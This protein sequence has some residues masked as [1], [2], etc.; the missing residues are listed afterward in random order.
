MEY[1]TVWDGFFTLNR[2]LLVGPSCTSALGGPALNAAFR[3]HFTAH[4]NNKCMHS[5]LDWTAA[6]VDRVSVRAFVR[7]VDFCS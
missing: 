7:A 5:T 3:V 4:K 6:M 2:R 1:H